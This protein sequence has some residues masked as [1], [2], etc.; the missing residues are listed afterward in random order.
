MRQ[1]LNADYTNRSGGELVLAVGHGA[2]DA[3]RDVLERGEVVAVEVWQLSI[4]Y[5]SMQGS[6]RVSPTKPLCVVFSTFI[7]FSPPVSLAASDKNA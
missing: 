3:V 5:S 2:E 7:S 4:G 6:N 1:F